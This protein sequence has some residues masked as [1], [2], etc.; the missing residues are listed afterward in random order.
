MYTCSPNNNPHTIINYLHASYLMNL[1]LLVRYI[2][3]DCIYNINIAVEKFSLVCGRNRGIP[4][5]EA[6][7]IRLQSLPNYLIY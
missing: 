7:M 2:I 4:I 6:V 3:L 1:R 5:T